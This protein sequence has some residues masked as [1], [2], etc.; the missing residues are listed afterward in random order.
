MERQREGLGERDGAVSL[1]TPAR[2]EGGGAE[3]GSTGPRSAVVV[4]TNA[5]FA[6]HVP[7]L[8]G[9]KSQQLA[10][11]WRGSSSA[12]RQVSASRS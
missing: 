6:S 2:E 5:P 3:E 9:T 1:P 7:S 12:S 8:A 10:V 4:A 11:R